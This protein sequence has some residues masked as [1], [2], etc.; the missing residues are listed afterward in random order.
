[1]TEL[2]LK[3]IIDESIKIKNIF[4]S[5]Q[6]I[7]YIV[8]ILSNIIIQDCFI[9]LPKKLE[10]GITVESVKIS[11]DTIKQQLD[12]KQ[13]AKDLVTYGRCIYDRKEPKIISINRYIDTREEAYHYHIGKL[14]YNILTFDKDYCLN[15]EKMNSCEEIDFIKE[16][17]I[18]LY[19]FN[20][21]YMSNEESIIFD[22][23]IKRVRDYIIILLRSILYKKYDR[24]T[25]CFYI[26]FD[27]SNTENILNNLEIDKIFSN[28]IF[29]KTEKITKSMKGKGSLYG[30]EFGEYKFK[31][32]QN[33]MIT[34]EGSLYG[35]KFGKIKL[36]NYYYDKE[37][38]QYCIDGQWLIPFHRKNKEI[39]SEQLIDINFIDDIIVKMRLLK[40]DL[41][42]KQKFEL[43]SYVRDSERQMELV[44][45]KFE[46]NN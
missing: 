26:G 46:E 37:L 9:K 39:Q 28:I 32:Q 13:A 35:K 45:E 10:L 16:T 2:E 34:G 6:N 1:M 22:T 29:P 25:Y 4:D 27:D 8:D 3:S 11:F 17:M 38:D 7:Q 23:F 31:E 12:L 14:K 44:L 41:I 24:L 21:S 18:P 43:A 15:I 20:K 33:V 30:K 40:L 5:N 42:K 36:E 19:Y